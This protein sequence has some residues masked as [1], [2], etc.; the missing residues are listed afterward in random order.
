MFSFNL[1]VA[2]FNQLHL[3]IHF[4]LHNTLFNTNGHALGIQPKKCTFFFSF[5]VEEFGIPNSFGL[6]SGIAL[7]I[8][9]KMLGMTGKSQI[10]KHISIF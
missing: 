5:G 1:Q 10:L 2:G 3:R 9:K 8:P 4:I 6:F 7:G